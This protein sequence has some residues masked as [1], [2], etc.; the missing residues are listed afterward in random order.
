M[1]I[2]THNYEAYL[3]DFIEGNLSLSDEIELREF[4]RLHSYLQIDLEKL[5]NFTL[6]PEKISFDK[7]NLLKENEETAISGISKIERLS[8][9]FLENEIEPKELNELNQLVENRKYLKVFNSIQRV[10]L[11]KPQVIYKNKQLLKRKS[12]KRI[13]TFKAN[14]LYRVAAFIVLLLSLTFWF[15]QR[16]DVSKINIELTALKEIPLRKTSMYKEDSLQLSLAANIS[17]Y[18]DSQNITGIK[19]NNKKEVEKELD[20]IKS[21]PAMKIS[22]INLQNID[23]SFAQNNNKVL[24][25]DINPE[26]TKTKFSQKAFWA[27]KKTAKRMLYKMAYSFRKNIHYKKQYLDDGKVLIA[28]K[29]GDFEYKRIKEVKKP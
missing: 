25:Q 20:F 3:L 13:F 9:A 4:V 10:K 1:K 16:K 23:F 24:L 28:L 22:T 27:A 2:N 7:K 26:N 12:S 11:N 8:I 19:T 17:K 6:V 5:D 15:S 21:R 18:N 14:F 29:A